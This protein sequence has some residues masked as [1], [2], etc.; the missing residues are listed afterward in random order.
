MFI[1]LTGSSGIVPKQGSYFGIV[2]NPKAGIRFNAVKERALKGLKMADPVNHIQNSTR[3]H[4]TNIAR[5]PSGLQA[6]IMSS[7]CTR[8]RLSFG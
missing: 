4:G 3:K 1:R 2:S 6:E 5:T 7:T 8:R